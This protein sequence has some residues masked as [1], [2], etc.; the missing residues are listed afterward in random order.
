MID[1]KVKVL[2]DSVFAAPGGWEGLARSREVGVDCIVYFFNIEPDINFLNVLKSYSQTSRKTVF[3]VEASSNL[4]L[5]E[6]LGAHDVPCVLKARYGMVDG[7]FHNE[8]DAEV[9]RKWLSTAIDR[10]SGRVGQRDGGF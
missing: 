2:T 5:I 6:K 7:M 4:K 10:S 3:L 8:T 1:E 9:L